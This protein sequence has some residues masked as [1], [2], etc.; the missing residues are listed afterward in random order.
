MEN[1][2]TTKLLLLVSLLQINERLVS[3][4]KYRLKVLLFRTLARCLIPSY[5]SSSL[6]LVSRQTAALPYIDKEARLY[7]V[8]MPTMYGMFECS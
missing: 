1:D 6:G 8:V 7:I 3:F 5:S 2:N 4:N